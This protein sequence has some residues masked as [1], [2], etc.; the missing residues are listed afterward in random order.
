[1]DVVYIDGLSYYWLV[2]DDVDVSVGCEVG[3][4][5]YYYY[6]YGEIMDGSFPAPV[7]V[8]TDVSDFCCYGYVR[9]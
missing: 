2:V 1:M 3:L 4:W 7:P 8:R 5:S 6:G 9:G